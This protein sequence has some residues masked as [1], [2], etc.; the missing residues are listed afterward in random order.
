MGPLIVLMVILFYLSNREIQ[1][2]LSESRKAQEILSSKL[3]ESREARLQE[4]TKAAEFGRLSQGLF[5]DLMTPLTSVILHTD[6]LKNDADAK[7][8][9]EKAIDAS[10]RMAEYAKDMRKSLAHEDEVRSLNLKEEIRAIEHLFT[11]RLRHENIKLDINISEDIQWF[12]NPLKFRQILSNL[13]SNA[14]DSY[15]NIERKEGKQIIVS[16]TKK[17]DKLTLVVS[18]NG[19][20]IPAEFHSKIFDPF[21]TTKSIE[22][23][24]GIG[25][26]TVKTLVEK[27]LNGTIKVESVVGKGSTFIITFQE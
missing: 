2:S 21:Y 13:I 25:L 8:S 23:G 16:I 17:I 1:K 11:Y 22:K 4:L 7:H 20:G 5:H 3:E 15:E 19:C 27:D 26:A 24:T 9:I 6:K 12:G 14:I 10:R 18:D